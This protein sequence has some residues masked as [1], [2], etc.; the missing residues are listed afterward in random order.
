MATTVGV[1]AELQRQHAH[2]LRYHPRGRVAANVCEGAVTRS[3][4]PTA[5]DNQEAY[6][7]AGR[8]VTTIAP[9]LVMMR[10]RL[11]RP[12]QPVPSHRPIWNKG[13]EP[14]PKNLLSSEQSPSRRWVICTRRGRRGSRP[15]ANDQRRPA[16]RR[17][18]RHCSTVAAREGDGAAI[19]RTLGMSQRSLARRLAARGLTLGKILDELRSDLAKR[20]IKDK[21]LSIS[22]IAWLV[23]Y[24]EVS[25]FTH[26]FKRWTGRTPSEMRAGAY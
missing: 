19:A 10:H 15:A 23:G 22:E 7:R 5:D 4:R 24:Q 3:K 21:D 18:E 6:A 16:I 12:C 26:A 9:R 11:D 2:C 17:R 1:A 25:A 20:H 14:Q 13:M 8:A